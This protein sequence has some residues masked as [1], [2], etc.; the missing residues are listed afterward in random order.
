MPKFIVIHDKG[1]ELVLNCDR[2]QSIINDPI[3]NS[4]F[5]RYEA[6]IASSY[7]THI[8]TDESFPEVMAMLADLD[9]V[10]YPK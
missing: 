7:T 1:S 2:I 5:I 8:I 9:C 4:A 6:P 3:H 10:R